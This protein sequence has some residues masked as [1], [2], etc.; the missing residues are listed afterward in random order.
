MG[1]DAADNN[2][3]DLLRGKL[4]LSSEITQFMA[5]QSCLPEYRANF[6]NVGLHKKRELYS[7]CQVIKCRQEPLCYPPP[8]YVHNSYLRAPVAILQERADNIFAGASQLDISP[9]VEAL[10]QP[11]TAVSTPLMPCPP[12]P[13]GRSHLG[14]PPHQPYMGHGAPRYPGYPPVRG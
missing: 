4:K 5:W 14:H 11:A 3:K 1:G 9:P 7:I 12:I 6:C 2:F 13:R 10:I 8:R